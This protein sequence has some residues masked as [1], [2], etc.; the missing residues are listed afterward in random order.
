MIFEILT[1]RNLFGS[2]NVRL[3]IDD[4]AIHEPLPFLDR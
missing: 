3:M 1:D 2:G 4:V